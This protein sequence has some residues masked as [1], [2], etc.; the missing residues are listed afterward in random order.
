MQIIFYSNTE[1]V[2]HLWVKRFGFI[3]EVKILVGEITLLI[4]DASSEV[5]K[6]LHSSSPLPSQQSVATT[7]GCKD[8]ETRE[9]HL[10]NR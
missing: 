1:H 2:E 3:S 9:S 4:V 10:N 5:S 8:G 6:I 7:S